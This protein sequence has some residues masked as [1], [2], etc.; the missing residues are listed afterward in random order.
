MNAFEVQVLKKLDEV[1]VEN[2]TLLLGV[3]G[4][5]DSIALMEVL[6]QLKEKRNL[7]LIVAHVHHGNTTGTYRDEAQRVVASIAKQKG[8]TFVFKK[9]KEEPLHP[10]VL[11][12]EA[13]LR[14]FRMA[15]LEELRC[16]HKAEYLVLAQH[17]NDLLETRLIR[18]VR[19][20]GPQGIESMKLKTRDLLRP[21]L[22]LTRAEIQD[23]AIGRELKWIEDPSN[24]SNEPLRNWM[25]NIWLPLVEEKRPGAI[26]TL[27]KSLNI[28]AQEHQLPLADSLV[29]KMKLD[30]GVDRF[31]LAKLPFRDQRR[32]L[33]EYIFAAGLKDYSVTH[34]DEILKRLDTPQKDFTFQ[35]LKREWRVDTKRIRVEPWT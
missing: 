7:K 5:M 1:G 28:L 29:N 4:G 13:E 33:A 25:R 2:Q 16:L 26:Y 3:S 34:I 9:F 27:M 18:L 31:E 30:E 6:F 11:E 32:V 20:V 24:Q 22:E 17:A 35:L 8:L 23:Y 12:S 14:A 21:F 19:G 10:K 15:A